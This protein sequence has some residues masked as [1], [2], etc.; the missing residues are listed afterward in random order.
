[1]RDDV[2]LLA[3]LGANAYRFSISWPRP[4]IG[5]GPGNEPGVDFYGAPVDELLHH[6][7]EPVVTLYHWICPKRWTTPE[8]GR[9]E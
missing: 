6:D 2:A 8:V 4:T 3:S 5:R 7:I 1:M 9:P